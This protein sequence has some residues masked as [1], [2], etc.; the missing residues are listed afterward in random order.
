[1]KT[2]E[3]ANALAALAQFLRAGPNVELNQLRASRHSRAKPNPSD[4][5]IALSAL[6]S[7]SQFDKSQ[8]RALIE[9]YKFPLEVRPAKSTR[10]IVGKILQTPGA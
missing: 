9:E 1:M 10:D 6:V 8:W 3:M 5:P 2:H 4:I 7:L